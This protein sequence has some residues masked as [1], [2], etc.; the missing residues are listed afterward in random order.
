MPLDQGHV[1]AGREWWVRGVL[2]MEPGGWRNGSFSWLPS[3]GGWDGK[4]GKLESNLECEGE[5]NINDTPFQPS[6]WQLSHF[7]IRFIFLPGVTAQTNSICDTITHEMPFAMR[8]LWGSST[9]E[10]NEGL[11]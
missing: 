8:E 6:I 9:D 3:R 1:R 10:E 7:S 11:S 2:R 4:D 5:V